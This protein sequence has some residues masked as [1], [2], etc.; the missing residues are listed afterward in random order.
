MSE[1]R[2]LRICLVYDHLFPHTVGGAERW[3]RDLGLHLVAAGNEVT[4]LTMRHW[5]AA[6]PPALTGVRVLGL[7][8]PGRVY[9]EDRRTLLPPL[10][11]GLA[12]ARH[13]WR[14]GSDYD[15]VH[16]ASFPYFPVLA[17]RAL[18]R[19]R[20]YRL[21]V[22]W[23]EVWTRTYWRRYAGAVVGTAG[24]LVQRAC[25]RMRHTAYCI[26]QM[27]ADRL[28]AEGYRGVPVVLPGLYA[29]AVEP[30][31]G[32]SVEPALVVYA[33]RHVREKR[34]DSLVRGFALVRE[35]RP[36]AR[37]E[38]YGDGP[39]RQ[40]LEVLVRSL[41]IDSSARIL[42]RRP[43]SEVE[44]A[45]ARAACVATASEREGYG[46]VVVEAA[47]R[48]TPSVIVDGPENA[49]IELVRE[50][51]NGAVAADASSGNLSAAILRV[52]DAGPTLRETTARWFAEN[53]DELRIDRSLELVVEDYRRADAS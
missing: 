40:R 1:S 30:A 50:G 31:P 13:L 2:P 45:M 14:N 3:M 20:G 22:N 17:A 43:E 27:H 7:T 9:R 16:V 46:L 23:L 21:V 25:V 44:D 29:G 12:V 28:V 26:S 5:T 15:V 8:D 4:Y 6:D 34:V 19:R 47:A 35:R 41:G 11:F 42:G 39:E 18:R 32:A 33:G 24:W 48:G 52:L 10:R 51:V 36:N 49:A 53:A 37:L 38:L